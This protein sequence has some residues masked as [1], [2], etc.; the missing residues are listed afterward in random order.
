MVKKLLLI[1][2]MGLLAG[3]DD[4][5]NHPILCDDGRS[6]HKW[7]RWTDDWKEAND[8]GFIRQRRYC[9]KCGVLELEMH[10]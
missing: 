8:F 10:R 1:M 4:T 6:A 9:D 3:C 7:S 2:M 5:H